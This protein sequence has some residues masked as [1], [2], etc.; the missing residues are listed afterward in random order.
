MN[1]GLVGLGKM[2]EPIARR[3]LAAGHDL[4]VWNRTP[5]R[6]DHLVEQ[7]ARQAASPREL[8]EHADVAI[9]MISDD[10]ALRAVTLGDAGLLGG[11]PGGGV[12]VD[13]ST[14]SVAASRQVAEAAAAAGVAYLRAPVTGN[15]SV[16]EAGNLGIIVS[17]DEAAFGR[18]DPLFHDIGPNVFYLGPAEE[19][20]VMKLAL[21]V[22][23]AGTAELLAEA[24]VLGEANGLDRARMLEV[25]GASAVGSPFVKYKTAALVADDYSSTFTS[26]A[27]FKDLS[28]ILECAAAA[29]VPLPVSALLQQLVLAC[30]ST[31]RGD[32]DFIALVPRLAREAGLGG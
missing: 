24:L 25:L 8:W 4:T 22:F 15:P 29:G 3:L 27:M 20:R 6:A 16:V 30:I 19:A 17:G 14:V 5:R 10:A 26:R 28:L 32:D 31:G 12:L 9:T 11:A 23:V 2:G 13:M 7:G 18:L 21:Q 1:V